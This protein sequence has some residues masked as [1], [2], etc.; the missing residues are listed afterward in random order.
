MRHQTL[1]KVLFE[2]VHQQ[3]IFDYFKVLQTQSEPT[4]VIIMISA[5]YASSQDCV[6]M[7][8]LNLI[9]RTNCTFIILAG[10]WQICLLEITSI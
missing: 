8:K 4:Q 10:T 6:G 1:F 3:K 5:D 2:T 9:N 7:Y